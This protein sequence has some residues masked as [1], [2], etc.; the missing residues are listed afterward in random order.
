MNMKHTCKIVLLLLASTPLI[1]GTTFILNPVDPPGTGFFDP[2]P[3]TPVGG[4]PGTTIGQQRLIAFQYALDIWGETLDSDV[5]VTVQAIFTPLSCSPTGGTLGAA[6]T[7]FIH[8]NFPTS[9]PAFQPNTWY[10]AALANKLAGFDLNPGPPD[11][12]F[13]QP[14][15]ADEMYALFNSQIDNNTSCLPGNWYYGLD[16]NPPP[17]DLDFL[18][19]LLHELG[20]GL[21]FSNFANESTGQPLSGLVDIYMRNTYDNLVGK[22][23]DQMTP[24][25]IQFSATNTGGV[26]WIG[27][28][29]TDNAP[30]F[31]ANRPS[32]TIT[33][34]AGIAGT[35]NAT[36]AN[37]GPGLDLSGVTGTIVLGND[38]VGTGSDGC[39]PLINADAA[40]N[41]V[42]IDRG[43]CSFVQKVQNAQAAGAIGVLVAN[44]QSTAIFNLGGTDNTI[45]IPSGMISLAD[46]NTIKSGLPATGT[47]R[48]DPTRFQGADDAGRVRLYAPAT[49]AAGSSISHF[50]TAATPSL[51]MEPFITGGLVGSETLDLTPYQMVDVGWDL[52]D[53]DGDGLPN[54]EDACP[55]GDNAATVVIDGCDS[56]VENLVFDDGCSISDTIA[57]I[58]ANAANHGDFVSQVSHFTNELK[59]A[60]LI[61][62]R[63]KGALTSCAGQADLP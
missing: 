30:N 59:S 5:P 22:S 7:V 10:H 42:L 37:F 46:G 11:P 6:S 54:I 43:S 34:P 48:L 57:N 35:Y 2:T 41:I 28:E 25:E 31:L 61:S 58:A 40:G 44:N 13:L 63:E 26:V 47:H 24:A 55:N 23:W 8:A 50:D 17:G 38:G 18:N 32:L 20:H 27:P 4:N 51:L 52:A 15:F 39:E 53:N 9:D 45:T 14:P 62:G 60:G 33:S 56:G 21:G 16:N 3:A 1:A 36:G 19:V 49:V 29:V 12:G